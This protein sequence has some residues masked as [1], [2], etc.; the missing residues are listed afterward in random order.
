MC[1]TTEKRVMLTPA[2]HRRKSIRVT[3]RISSR[4]NVMQDLWIAVQRRV[5]ETNGLLANG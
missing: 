5:D 3:A 1:S 4:G 2:F